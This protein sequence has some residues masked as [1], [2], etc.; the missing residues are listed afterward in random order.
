MLMLLNGKPLISRFVVAIR[1]R[2][3]AADR[4]RAKYCWNSTARNERWNGTTH[5]SVY[6]IEYDEQRAASSLDD[7]AAVLLDGRVDQVPTE[8]PKTTQRSGVI[9][10][11]ISWSG[12]TSHP[13]G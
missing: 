11:A 12:D 1:R 9:Q 8:C 6:A 7:P 2:W 13:K 10:V 4:R 5:R 3:R